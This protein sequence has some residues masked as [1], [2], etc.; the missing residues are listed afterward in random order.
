MS[1]NTKF[2]EISSFIWNVCDDVLR[3][4]FKAHEYWDVILPFI[5]LRRLD[6][7]MEPHKTKVVEL[8][9]SLKSEI[10]S[11]SRLHHSGEFEWGLC[12]LMENVI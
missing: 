3:G 12:F 11:I 9:N 5:T 1:N 6:C 7:M 2:Q 4:L 8:Y 10:T